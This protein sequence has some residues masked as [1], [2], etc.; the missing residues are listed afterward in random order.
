VIP[1]GTLVKVDRVEGV[2]VFV[3]PVEIPA[4]V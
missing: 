2:K 1:E 3:T 4:N